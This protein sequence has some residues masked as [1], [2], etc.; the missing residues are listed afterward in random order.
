M[1]EEER[2][3]EEEEE[4]RREEEEKRRREKEE[5]QVWKLLLV[6]LEVWNFGFEHLFCL[7]L[8]YLLVW[9]LFVWI[10]W[11]GN[12]HSSLFAYVWGFKNPIS[13]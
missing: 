10:Y 13:V 4:R 11:L 1:G 2:R 12:P 5:I 7:E 6:C 9:N 3:K 8:L